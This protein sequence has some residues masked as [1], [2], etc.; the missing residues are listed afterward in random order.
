MSRTDFICLTP[1]LIIASAPVIMMLTITAARNFRVIYGFSLLMYA[2]ALVSLFLILPS[3]PH[4]IEPLLIIDNYSVLFLGLIFG[5]SLLITVISYIYLTGHSGQREEYFIVLFVA[6]LGASVLVTASHFVTFFLG[7]ET[8]SISLYILI[9]YLKHRDYSVEAAVKFLVI[10]SVSTAFLLFGMALL[11]AGS[12]TM[13]F[14]GIAACFEKSGISPL[15]L[16]GIG[17]MLVGIGFKLA[18]VPFHMWIPDVYQGAPAPVTAFIATISKGS[19]LAIVIRFLFTIGGIHDERIILVISVLAILSMFTGN[20]LALR[21]TNFKRLLAYSSIAH[22]GYLMITVLTGTPE[23]IQA[24]LFYL[25]SYII[26]TLGAFGVISILSVC[27]SE[28]DRVEDLTGLF[29]KNPWLAIVLSLT[30]LSLAGIPLTAGF[31]SKFYLSLS[32]IRSGLWLLVISLIINSVISLYYYLRVI[33]IM[34]TP[35]AD[36][37]FMSLPLMGHVVLAIVVIG[38][39]LLGLLPSFLTEIIGTFSAMI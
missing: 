37:Q 15:M 14:K 10:A 9:G 34:F 4:Q 28:S 3:V 8:L 17:M 19:V 5:T 20:L 30:M 24:A 32:G 36:R 21:Q 18:L 11:Y 35:S 26:T 6:T 27:D 38:I 25:I 23:G 39:L 2:A 13:S 7:L 12:G 1:L 33:R 22:L 16:A 29:W 31:I